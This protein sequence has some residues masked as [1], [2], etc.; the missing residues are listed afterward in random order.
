MTLRKLIEG[1]EEYV[2]EIETGIDKK[3][4]EKYEKKYAKR[5]V[6]LAVR[7]WRAESELKEIKRRA[8]KNLRRALDDLD[9]PSGLPHPDSAEVFDILG[10][11]NIRKE[12][13]F[14][15]QG[16][17]PAS[18]FKGKG[19]GSP[20]PAPPI[21]EGKGKGKGSRQVVL[22]ARRNNLEDVVLDALS[23]A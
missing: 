11:E 22:A 3:Y 17:V 7:V 15:G 21:S 16:K 18:A 8:Q 4:E 10:Y 9:S 19:K 12:Q 13:V 20:P 1:H 2:A 23:G 14:E 6:E 5:N